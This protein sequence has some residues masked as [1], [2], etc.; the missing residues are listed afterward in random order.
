MKPLAPLSTAALL[1][2]VGCFPQ[3]RAPTP[4]E[5]SESVYSMQAYLNGPLPEDLVLCAKDFRIIDD[6]GAVGRWC[7][8]GEQAC[9]RTNDTLDRR[10]RVVIVAADR[11]LDLLRHELTHHAMECVNGDL[12]ATHSDPYWS[13]PYWGSL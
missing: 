5:I 3:G 7:D 12:D 1:L 2:L 9:Y 8:P 13:A 11:T 4:Y 10:D 6:P